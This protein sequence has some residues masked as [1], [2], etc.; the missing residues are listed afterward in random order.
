MAGPQP[1]T[2]PGCSNQGSRDHYDDNMRLPDPTRRDSLSLSV[3]MLNCLY[4]ERERERERLP[5][6]CF[7]LVRSGQAFYGK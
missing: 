7:L 2:K 3:Y 1:R 5:V 4:V 6:L